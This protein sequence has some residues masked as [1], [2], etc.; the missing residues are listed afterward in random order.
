MSEVKEIIEAQVA[1][2]EVQRSNVE[3]IRILKSVADVVHG[4]RHDLLFES[5][6]LVVDLADLLGSL[7][8]FK[9]SVLVVPPV[10]E[11]VSK[12]RVPHV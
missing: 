9:S 11:E 5:I 7:V 6:V 3:I 2:L 4:W 8:D 10:L 1:V 12:L